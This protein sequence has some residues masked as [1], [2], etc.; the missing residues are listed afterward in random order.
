MQQST[1]YWY[2]QINNETERGSRG[3]EG[4]IDETTT[5]CIAFERMVFHS[6]VLVR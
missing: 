6:T 3:S 2:F 1:R 5:T 4:V